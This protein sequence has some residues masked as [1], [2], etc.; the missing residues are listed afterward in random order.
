[1]KEY[2]PSASNL[3]G[4]R[5]LGMVA[6]FQWEV[7]P[8]LRQLARDLEATADGLDDPA[9]VERLFGLARKYRISL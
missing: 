4:D 7:R 5:P 3:S 9:H 8:L 1:M 2:P 6:A